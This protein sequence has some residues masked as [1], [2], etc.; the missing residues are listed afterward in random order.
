M[1]SLHWSK[2]VQLRAAADYHTFIS[3]V[4]HALRKYTTS[5]NEKRVTEA[6]NVGKDLNVG[7]LGSLIGPASSIQLRRLSSS[8]SAREF[9][10]RQIVGLKAMAPEGLHQTL[11]NKGTKKKRAESEIL[12]RCQ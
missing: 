11:R 7:K 8:C 9:R 10:H 4:A 2:S 6:Y 12:F 5:T 1:V 3:F